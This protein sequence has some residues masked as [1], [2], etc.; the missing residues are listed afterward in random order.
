MDPRLFLIGLW[1]HECFRTFQDKLITIEDQ[2]MYCDILDKITK[3]KFRE[4]LGFEDEQL[5]T[6]L[7]FAD[8]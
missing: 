1:R 3:E 8:F 2:K 4:T 7:M 6:N 5:L